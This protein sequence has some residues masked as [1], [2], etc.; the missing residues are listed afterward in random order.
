MV[1]T[2]LPGGESRSEVHVVPLLP[3]DLPARLASDGYVGPGAEGDVPGLK[4]SVLSA[5]KVAR[6]R[7]APG[8]EVCVAIRSHGA[9]SVPLLAG[10]V[11]VLAVECDDTGP[12][13]AASLNARSLSGDDAVAV[14]RFV[15]RHRHLQRVVIH[16][17]AGVSRSRSVAA[18]LAETF[19]LPYR[20][21]AFNADIVAAMRGAAADLRDELTT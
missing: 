5:S 18:V 21:T 7:P 9:A 10:W 14:L 1:A 6:Y 12:Y 3:R 15:A 13:A 2:P 20:W 16:C 17:A 11:A 19:G 8:G 4:M